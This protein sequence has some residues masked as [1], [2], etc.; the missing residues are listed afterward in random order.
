[1]EDGRRVSMFDLQIGDRVLSV[2]PST[3]RQFIDEVVT[4]LHREMND[5]NDKTTYIRLSL[6]N[7]ASIT[8]T[9]LHMIYFVKASEVAKRG[10]SALLEKA[11]PKF[12][13]RVQPGDYLI[14]SDGKAGQFELVQVAEISFEYNNAGKFAP[15]TM[16]GN[17][18]VDGTVAS[19]YAQYEWHHLAHISM[20]PL[21]AV[22]TIGK[23]F[24]NIWPSSLYYD[25]DNTIS[26]GIH[27]YAE[28]LY[29]TV[30]SFMASTSFRVLGN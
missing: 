28:F 11:K 21:R 22:N 26:T 6:V 12:A 7:G 14:H 4:F 27:P 9:P 24:S 30:K 18:V 19:C 16:S 5:D 25:S 20:A 8:L 15:M 29:N 1:M 13:L 23:Y 17:I 2:D 3:G 10:S